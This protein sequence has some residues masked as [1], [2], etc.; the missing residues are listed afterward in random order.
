[1]NN[2]I[3]IEQTSLEHYILWYWVTQGGPKNWATIKLSKNRIKS[4]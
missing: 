3:K 1:M 2:R 4:N